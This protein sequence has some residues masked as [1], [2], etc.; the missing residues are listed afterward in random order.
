M[1]LTDTTIDL[2]ATGELGEL[3]ELSEL[4]ADAVEEHS[5]LLGRVAVI[6]GSTLDLEELLHRLANVALE[7]T[8][9]AH[10]CVFLLEGRDLHPTAA[11]GTRPDDGTWATLRELGP[12]HLDDER[13]ERVLTGPA[14]GTHDVAATRVVPKPWRDRF[15]PGAVALVPIRSNGRPYGVLAL[16]WS[17]PGPVDDGHLRLLQTVA[18]YAAL[19][20]GNARD[21]G[22][23]QRRARL[24][25]AL[26]RGASSLVGTTD[27][28]VVAEH[29]ADAYT[30]L[31]PARLCAV[32]LLDTE[33]ERITTVA[34]R[35]TAP[36]PGRLPLAELSDELVSRIWAAWERSKA[37]LELRDEPCIDGLV[38]AAAREVGWY[39]LVPFVVQER[40]QG[41]VLLGFGAE[42]DLRADERL[43]VSALADVAA[44]ALERCRLI[45]G[46]ARQLDRLRALSEVSEA[47]G[48]G[49]DA[50]VVVE[51]LNRIL[52][53]HGI[54]VDGVVFAG[55]DV[56][57]HLR[58]EAPEA[59]ERAAWERGE[60]VVELDGGLR[61]IAIR[62]DGGVAGALRVRAERLG[63]DELAFLGALA[64]GVGEVAT[65]E[66]LRAALEVAAR[67]RAIVEERERFAGDLHDTAGQVFVAIGLMARDHADRL[68]A[69]SETRDLLYRL[70]DLASGGKWEISLAGRALTFEPTTARGLVPAL[71][72]L[73]DEF[74]GDSGLEVAFEVVGDEERLSSGRERALFR[75]AHE[76]LANAWRHGAPERAVVSVAFSD[77]EVSVR[78]ADDGRGPAGGEV[79]E[80]T[81]ITGM[82]RAVAEVGGR[83]RVEPASPGGRSDAGGAGRASGFVVE[84]WVPKGE[85]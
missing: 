20:I 57:R 13:W 75:V 28:E 71:R 85:R 48:R 83:L 65:R 14:F 38:G 67:D 4:P 5:S 63:E 77:A 2:R 60:H 70:A 79:V 6:L 24:Q 19:A 56:R 36:L 22:T 49:A 15:A 34:S 3:G 53:E 47:L 52:V 8:G 42:C 17:D 46:Q 55:D 7:A 12:V 82:R 50:A 64:R 21:Y 16:D 35:G 72:E 39:L 33:R 25:Q 76:A 78:V 31:V 84:A 51:R 10:S 26:A 41:F 54:E 74:R 9:A 68:P 32:A 45:D 81:G 59:A 18:T 73:I 37:P 58:A 80:G 30:E 27:R 62:L 69:G 29:V 11:V 1:A 44:G 43:A 23:A 40:T 61:S 66:M